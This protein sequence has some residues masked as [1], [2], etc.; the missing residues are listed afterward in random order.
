MEAES[1]SQKGVEMAYHLE[2]GRIMVHNATGINFKNGTTG[3]H[4]N[5]RQNRPESNSFSIKTRRGNMT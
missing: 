2:R 4:K 1:S 5:K 3:Y